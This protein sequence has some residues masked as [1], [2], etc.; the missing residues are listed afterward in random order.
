[1]ATVK[2][3][4]KSDIG[5]RIKAKL[6]GLAYSLDFLGIAAGAAGCTSA[7]AIGGLTPEMFK[8]M[9]CASFSFAA[10]M[11][12]ATGFIK[13][14]PGERLLGVMYGAATWLAASVVRNA[15]PSADASAIPRFVPYVVLIA[16]LTATASAISDTTAQKIEKG[17]AQKIRHAFLRT[18]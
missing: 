10:V 13:S 14:R 3:K 11:T 9:A 2:D 7:R 15:G 6:A 17:F 5:T 8:D 1:M 4:Q 18:K 16:L 12:V